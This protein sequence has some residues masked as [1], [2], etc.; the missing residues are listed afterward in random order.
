MAQDVKV[1]PN[2]IE[3]FV[4][5]LGGTINPTAVSTSVNVQVFNPM[6]DPTKSNFYTYFN[7][8]ETDPKIIDV[9][10]VISG[11]SPH[12]YTFGYKNSLHF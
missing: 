1:T 5:S 2:R 11:T 8:E 9:F 7:D 12:W 3:A 6:G 4:P 10:R